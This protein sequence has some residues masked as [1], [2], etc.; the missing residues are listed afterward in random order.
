[1]SIKVKHNAIKSQMWPFDS[2]PHT[3]FFNS[4]NNFRK[5]KETKK[6]QKQQVFDN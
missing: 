4:A 1:M 6:I 5:I 2:A 3:F